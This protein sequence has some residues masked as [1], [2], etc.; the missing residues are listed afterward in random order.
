VRCFFNLPN[1]DGRVD[2]HVDVIRSAKKLHEP[3]QLFEYSSVNTQALVLLAE[4]VEHRPWPQ[5]LQ[6]RVWS[7]L[8]AEGDAMVSLTPDGVAMPCGFVSMRLR[9]LARYGMLYTPSWNRA[10]REQVV[11]ADVLKKI[12]TGGRPAIYPKAMAEHFEKAKT[13]GG[14]VPVANSRQWDSVFADGDFFKSGMS[15]QGLYVSPGKDLV[16]AW[17]STAPSTDLPGYA[18]AI[19]TTYGNGK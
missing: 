15:G 4:A 14:E 6:E 9:D 7:K 19:V 1:A 10:A 16:I 18:R 12:Q 11:S 3:G 13:F 8:N 2:R 5:I 17:F